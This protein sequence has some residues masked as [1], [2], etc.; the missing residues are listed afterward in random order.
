[1]FASARHRWPRAP[2]GPRQAGVGGGAPV[3]ALAV[4]PASSS[5]IA[6]KQAEQAQAKA[7]AARSRT[8]LAAQIDRYTALCE[9][10][11]RSQREI[12]ANTSELAGLD[13]K[14]AEVQARLNE[15]A[16]LLYE[17]R[18]DHIL[19]LFLTSHTLEDFFVR[20]EYL[21]RIGEYDSALVEEVKTTREQT[22]RGRAY[23]A[24]RQLALVQQQQQADDERAR[25]EQAI[26]ANE[27]RAKTLGQ[28]VVALQAQAAASA[29]RAGGSAPSGSFDPN[30]LI[31]EANFTAATSMSEAD[32]QAF[33]DS[34]PGILK[35]Y[36]AV[37]RNGIS[38]TTAQLITSAAADNQVSPK[39]ILA[40]LQKEQSLLGRANPTQEALD[41][42]MGAGKADSRTFFE[43]KGFGKQIWWGAY[44]LKKNRGGWGQGATQ[45]ID[46]STVRAT[47][48]ATY[49]LWEYTPHMGGNTSF[50][51]IYWRYFGDPGR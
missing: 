16:A 35:S 11:E 30:T 47:N 1:V 43:Y 18:G 5:E 19:E 27:A 29:S 3:R 38:R 14:L 4:P 40:T 26:A 8:D 15:R 21:L 20:A 34:Q 17:S 31:S 45:E 7:E 10:L 49:S 41:W 13:A 28:D 46:G 33:L 9:A 44:K 42:A 37:D 48:S 51:M 39:V 23:L 50:W 25:I 12:S 24:E 6:S 36:S 22:E 32:I 2:A